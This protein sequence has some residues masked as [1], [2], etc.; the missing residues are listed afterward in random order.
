MRAAATR[1]AGDS[2]QPSDLTTFL[3]ASPPPAQRALAEGMWVRRRAQVMGLQ[4]DDVD[5]ARVAS[6]GGQHAGSW[7][8]CVPTSVDVRATARQ[9]QLALAMRL[10]VRLEEVAAVD[11]R[12]R[13]C[14]CGHP[15]D[16]WGRHPGV[17]PR[18]NR[19]ALWTTRHDA[20]QAAV[21]R[22][23]R[24][25]GRVAHAVGRVVWF[26]GGALAA[27]GRSAR[28]L[29]ADIVVPHYRAPG[30]HLYVDVAVTTPDTQ[31]A[32][33]H[34]PSSRDSGGVAAQLRASKKH[35]KYGAAVAAQGG[36]FRAGVMERFGACCD[37][38]VGLVRGFCGDGARD[39]SDED[40]C[41]TSPTRLGYHMQRVVFA[42]VMADAEMVDRAL[43]MDI[44][45]T[46]ADAAR[47]EAETS[48]FRG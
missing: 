39:A 18:G 14:P 17:C 32:L 25:V 2:D 3:S 35:S 44:D 6:A 26:S 31:E 43:D 1:L 23:A 12:Q 37:D 46:H 4:T 5:R 16:V 21:L 48:A 27:A 22:V 11:I 10:G 7:L 34:R 40:W 24:R 15:H 13:V 8:A 33:G 28:G 20:L 42:G 41:F 47:D 29:Y 36:D 9:F 30:R 38:L 45:R 19:A